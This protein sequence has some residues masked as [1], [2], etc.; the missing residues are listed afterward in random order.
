MGGSDAEMYDVASVS[1]SHVHPDRPVHFLGIGK[2]KDVF[3]FVR[4][5]VDTF[6]CVIP[7][8][9]ARH[10]AAFVKGEAKETINLKNARYRDDESPLDDS[11]G[12]PASQNFSKAYIHHLLKANE[13]LAT[14]ILAQHNIATMNKLMREVRSAIISS[15]LDSLEKEWLGSLK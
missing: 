4:L 1:M 9:L 5:G 8:R 13:L 14:Q 12:I 7:T 2:I 15:N 3:T 10:G 11:I 6:D